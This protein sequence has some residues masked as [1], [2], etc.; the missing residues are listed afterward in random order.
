MVIFHERVFDYFHSDQKFG[1]GE[2]DPRFRFAG[3]IYPMMHLT[4]D[5]RFY[6]AGIVYQRSIC[7]L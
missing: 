4:V 2:D 6:F 1:K 5:S 3:M 7:I